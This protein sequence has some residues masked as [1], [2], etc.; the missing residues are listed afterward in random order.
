MKKPAGTA[1]LIAALWLC[2]APIF[3][4]VVVLKDGSKIFARGKYTV[5]GA[6][7]IITLENGNI[8]QLPLTQVDVPGTDKYNTVNGGAN[9]IDIN[10]PQQQTIATPHTT[11]TSQNLG[12]FIH[13]HEQQ[14]QQRAREE[15]AA[16]RVQAAP[17]PPSSPGT[18]PLGTAAAAVL[19]PLNISRYKIAAGPKIVFVTE[20]EDQVFAAIN[21]AARLMTSLSASGQ[22]AALDVALQTPDGKDAG[23]FRMTSASVAPLLAG[24]TTV[25]QFFVENVIF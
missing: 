12:Q 4:Y 1:F 11:T 19:G 15:K 10:T 5:R 25:S 16:Q 24:S 9:V 18:S 6:N 22:A 2:A 14:L 3:A 8:T 21:G 20:N 17:A 23:H 7:A 13:S